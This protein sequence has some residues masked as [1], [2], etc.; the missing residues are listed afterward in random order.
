MSDMYSENVHVSMCG[1]MCDE[2]VITWITLKLVAISKCQRH[3][4]GSVIK[5]RCNLVQPVCCWITPISPKSSCALWFSCVLV[6]H[7]NWFGS[8]MS[9]PPTYAIWLAFWCSF[10][11]SPSICLMKKLL[12]THA[13][14]WT[15]RWTQTVTKR[16][17][18]IKSVWVNAYV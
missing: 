7:C 11:P 3:W 10:L 12:I 13:G 15:D 17:I 1:P 14:R 8:E 16:G 5:P 9:F 2:S 4:H 18:N 6:I